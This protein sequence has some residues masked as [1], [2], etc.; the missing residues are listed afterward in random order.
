MLKCQQ[1]K[2]GVTSVGT[3]KWL[4]ITGHLLC[5]GFCAKCY[6]Y[7]ISFNTGKTLMRSILLFP[8]FADEKMKAHSG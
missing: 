6:T 5:D 2:S 4:K 7:I 8:L 1:Y 3:S